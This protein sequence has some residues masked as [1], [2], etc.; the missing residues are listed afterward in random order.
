MLRVRFC[1]S[2]QVSVVM[3]FSVKCPSVKTI[4]MIDPVADEQQQLASCESQHLL[5]DDVQP[6]QQHA[7]ERQRDDEHHEAVFP[8]VEEV[9][10]YV[11]SD[12]IRDIYDFCEADSPFSLLCNPNQDCHDGYGLMEYMGK[13]TFNS[14]GSPLQINVTTMAT[15]PELNQMTEFCHCDN[16]NAT[17][18][19]LPQNSRMTSCVG[20]CGSLCAVSSGDYRTYTESCY[21]TSNA[22][23]TSS[24]ASGSVGSD[25]ST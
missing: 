15:V 16:V 14:I 1:G 19:I 22:V 21:G 8:A 20:V 17:N 12:W 2:K 7:S 9:T 18:C 24:S 23:A 6:Q 25:D 11:G 10:Y 5:P 3:D 4:V 13:Y